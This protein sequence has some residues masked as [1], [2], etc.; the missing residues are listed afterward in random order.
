MDIYSYKALDYPAKQKLMR[1]AGY[2]F[3]IHPECCDCGD[4][5][6]QEAI[7]G[8]QWMID[9]YNIEMSHRIDEMGFKSAQ[10]SWKY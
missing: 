1:K 3:A 9:A 2:P 5:I 7:K 4:A 6:K 10:E 8:F